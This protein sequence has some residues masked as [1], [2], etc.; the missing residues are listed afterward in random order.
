MRAWIGLVSHRWTVESQPSGADVQLATPSDTSCA[1]T[2]LTV[3]GE[4]VFRFAA[5][6]GVNTST[7]RLTVPVYPAN[8][9][10]A[11]L[12]ARTQPTHTVGESHSGH[13]SILLRLNR[14][15]FQGG[16]MNREMG[17]RLGEPIRLLTAATREGA[18]LN[19]CQ[20]QSILL[21]QLAA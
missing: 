20:E 1:A 10:P 2:G 18:Q 19:H 12:S 9:A 7:A 4:Y 16:T 21:D 14:F 17:Q 5:S 11:I 8:M 13:I 6:E 3:A 15:S